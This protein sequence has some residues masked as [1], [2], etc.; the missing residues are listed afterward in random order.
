MKLLAYILI[1]LAVM[2]AGF[3]LLMAISAFLF[4]PI[5]LS[6]RLFFGTA[7]LAISS[8]L[9]FVARKIYVRFVCQHED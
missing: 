5:E 6:D 4:V 2:A 9:A 7:M 3:V 8:V 1:G